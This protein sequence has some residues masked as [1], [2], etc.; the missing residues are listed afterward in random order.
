[1]KI[2]I[3]SPVDIKHSF[4]GTDWHEYEY[5]KFLLQNGV[6][7]EILVTNTK[8]SKN[9]PAYNNQVYKNYINVPTEKVHCT[10]L[11]LPFKWHLFIHWNLPKDRIIYLPFSVYDYILN[12]VTRPH[13]QKYIIGNHGMHLKYGHIVMNHNVIEAVLNSFIRFLLVLRSYD[14]EE[15]YYHVLNK[16]QMAYLMALGIKRENIFHVPAMVDSTLYKIGTN[17]SKRLRILHVGGVGKGG[18]IVIKI[19]EELIRINKIDNFD[20]CFVGDKAPQKA[21]EYA[22][23]YSNIIVEGI[24][25]ENQ[26]LQLLPKYDIMIV[27]FFEVFPKNNA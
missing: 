18:D 3:V 15:V 13:N 6:D 2:G 24:I 8:I 25:S 22:K 14:I 9:K 23:K 16:G 7:A 20:F 12:I 19:I 17:K 27:P 5:A 26:K 10:E 21:Y 11:L 4:T 1:M